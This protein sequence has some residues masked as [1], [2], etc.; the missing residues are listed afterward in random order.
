MQTKNYDGVQEPKAA[1]DAVRSRRAMQHSAQSAAK[2]D[3]LASR[4]F[5]G[6]HIVNHLMGPSCLS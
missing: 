1:G 4:E 2:D 6:V 3:P 5:T